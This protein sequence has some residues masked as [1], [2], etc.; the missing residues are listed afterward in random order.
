MSRKRSR[1][2][3]HGAKAAF[4]RAYGERGAK[5]IIGDHMRISTFELLQRNCAC[6][7]CGLGLKPSTAKLRVACGSFTTMPSSSF[8]A[9]TCGRESAARL[10]SVSGKEQGLVQPQGTFQA[11]DKGEQAGLN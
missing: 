8:F 9:I 4:W 7:Q 11:L 1:S 10:L 6:G 3:C 5:R 2:A